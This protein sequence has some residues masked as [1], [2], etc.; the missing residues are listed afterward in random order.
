MTDINGYL[1]LIS[2]FLYYDALALIIP[3][4]Y[5]IINIAESTSKLSISIYG[6]LM[7]I[8]AYTNS[9]IASIQDNEIKHK[10][11]N[12]FLAQSVLLHGCIYVNGNITGGYYHFT[13]YVLVYSYLVCLIPKDRTTL[14]IKQTVIH[15]D[16]VD[17]CSLSKKSEKKVTHTTQTLE[18]FLE[19][20][21]EHIHSI[22][23]TTIT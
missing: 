7:L 4:I 22:T 15:I 13:P 12:I 6:V 14:S 11:L 19:I 1:N 17:E 18:P 8:W 23:P 10:F 16:P 2:C 5:P 9:Y 3:Q 20:S 21:E